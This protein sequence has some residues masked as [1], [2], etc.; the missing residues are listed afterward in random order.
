[1]TSIEQ[2]VCENNFEKSAQNVLRTSKHE[3]RNFGGRKK[4]T[5][6]VNYSILASFAQK[7]RFEAKKRT[8]EKFE[9]EIK[10]S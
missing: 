10:K 2:L 7:S 8:S 1:M 3:S 6:V 9:R 4:E 5:F